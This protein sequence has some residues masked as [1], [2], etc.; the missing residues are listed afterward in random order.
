MKLTLQAIG[1][2][3]GYEFDPDYPKEIEKYAGASKLLGW[4]PKGIIGLYAMCNGNRDHKALG[5]I[6]FGIA[7]YCKQ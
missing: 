3:L 7:K 4:P 6:R 2:P 1:G 5:E